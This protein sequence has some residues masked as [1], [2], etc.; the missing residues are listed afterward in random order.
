MTSRAARRR[1]FTLV[2]LLVAM[3]LAITLLGLAVAVSQTAA[4][5]SYRT[6]GAADKVS[7]WLIIAKN[8]ATRDRQVR[9]LRLLATV[10]A[11]TPSNTATVSE[12][13]YVEAPDPW[14]PQNPNQFLVFQQVIDEGDARVLPPLPAPAPNGQGLPLDQKRVLSTRVFL[15]GGFNGSDFEFDN[16]PNINALV[17]SGDTLYVPDLG[18]RGFRIVGI[19]TPSAAAPLPTFVAGRQTATFPIQFHTPQVNAGGGPYPPGLV[20]ALNPF[21]TG[22]P[23]PAGQP[24]NNFSLAAAIELQL[25]DAP[26]FSPAYSKF[27]RWAQNGNAPNGNPTI[28]I[29]PAV[30]TSPNPVYLAPPALAASPTPVELPFGGD[31]TSGVTPPQANPLNFQ[32]GQQ[33]DRRV[34]VYVTNKFGFYR[35]PRPLL[36]EANLQIPGMV[37]D[38]TPTTA[39]GYVGSYAPAGVPA[40]AALPAV[41]TQF[42]VDILFAPNGEVVNAP[43]P[44]TVLLLRDPNRVPAVD[45]NPANTTTYNF[46]AA[47]QM[48]LVAIYTRTGSVATKP[49]ANPQTAANNDPFV[50]AKDG[51]NGG[52]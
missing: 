43:N 7:Q 41:G 32:D 49:V 10:Q 34:P 31:N 22:T 28:L 21:P 12:C 11:N 6:V 51:I 30:P 50:F 15:C 47:G 52:L 29:P 2:E 42:P 5:D 9:G 45:M 19:T 23:V 17:R 18:G 8:R 26:V 27:V 1:G 48:A 33:V 25:A 4:F 14:T 44:I 3:A 13:Q 39:A 46:D 40:P 16:T 37:I 24:G 20:A 38:L 36:G 35:S